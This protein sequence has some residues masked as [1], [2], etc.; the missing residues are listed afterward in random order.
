[1]RTLF[2]QA[3]A[4]CSIERAFDRK[5]R[6][7]T[8]AEGVRL[9]VEGGDAIAFHRALAEFDSSSWLSARGA[10]VVTGATGHNLRDPRILLADAE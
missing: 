2:A 1:L 5:L 9:L 10:T 8:N 4:E 6:V 7:V 3:L